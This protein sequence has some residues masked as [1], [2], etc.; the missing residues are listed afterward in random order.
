VSIE[1]IVH[2]RTDHIS[3]VALVGRLDVIAMK[4]VDVRFRNETAACERPAI[5]DLTRLEFITSLG[6][7]MLFGC[8]RTLTRKGH[9]MVLLGSNGFVDT[10]LRVVG[11]HEVIPFADTLEDALRL[12]RSSRS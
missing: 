4:E 1:L 10:T 9:T 12:T 7:G 5:V 8:A 11:M 3:H 6:V 2:P